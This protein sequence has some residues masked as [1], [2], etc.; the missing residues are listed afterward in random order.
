MDGQQDLIDRAGGVPGDLK[1]LH[2]VK[3]SRKEAKE[4]RKFIGR[5]DGKQSK[6]GGISGTGAGEDHYV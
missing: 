4:H 5:G 2:I 6:K 3:E 1:L